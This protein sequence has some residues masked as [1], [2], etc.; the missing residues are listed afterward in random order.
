MA[1]R[2]SS[3]K[4]G[5]LAPAWLGKLPQ[6]AELNDML[7]NTSIVDWAP[8]KP[9]SDH[10]AI[11]T[12]NQPDKA[13]W[14]HSPDPLPAR[15]SG[16]LSPAKGELLRRAY[17]TVQSLS[18]KEK[19]K[20]NRVATARQKALEFE[21]KKSILDHRSSLGRSSAR[22]PSSSSGR[23]PQSPASAGARPTGAK[24]SPKRSALAPPVRR[25]A[26]QTSPVGVRL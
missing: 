22:S 14:G 4:K 8:A 18:A 26:S 21:Q 7:P 20:A 12:P 2:V 3:P 1:A 16:R 10:L 11:A 23:R 6:Q 17:P 24:V 19:E 13:S 5:I 9:L 15:S 25:G